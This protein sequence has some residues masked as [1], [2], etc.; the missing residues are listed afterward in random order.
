MKNYL[1]PF[2]L[3]LGLLFCNAVYG[4]ENAWIPAN[5]GIGEIAGKSNFDVINML[6]LDNGQI[7]SFIAN[8]SDGEEKDGVYL[9]ST[10]DKEWIKLAPRLN[11]Y[12][13]S[14]LVSSGTRIFAVSGGDSQ[15]VTELNLS[16]GQWEQKA[17][18]P[19]VGLN[20]SRGVD[21]LG[22]KL[23]IPCRI[24]SDKT[25]SEFPDKK[26]QKKEEFVLELDVPTGEISFLRNI[27]KPLIIDSKGGNPGKPIALKNGKVY[28]CSP[29]DYVAN[30]GFG[31]LYE[32]DGTDWKSAS[33]GLNGI[34][35]TGSGFGPIGPIFSDNK[36]EKLYIKTEQGFYQKA[37]G[38]WLKY[39][40]RTGSILAITED[41]LF[42]QG[43]SGNINRVDAALN[44]EVTN[45]GQK[46]I[47]RLASFVTP[48]N[49]KTF[50]AKVSVRQTAEGECSDNDDDRK[51]AGIFRFNAAF[52]SKGKVKNLHL[53]A[54][55]YLGGE[56]E[57][58]VAATA[59]SP[60][61]NVLVAG[62]F[63][64]NMG[65]TNNIL[66]GASAEGIGKILELDATGTEV[67]RATILGENISDMDV[68]SNGEVAVI[69]DFGV[70]VLTD[71][72]ALKWNTV[73]G[74]S[75]NAAIAI[76]DDGKVIVV[77]SSADQGA[78]LVKLFN[79]DG[80]L[81]HENS[82]M[83]NN[84]VTITDVEINSSQNQYFV[85]GYTQVSSVLQVAFLRAFSADND[86]SSNW[87]TWGF[88]PNEI[89]TNENGADT[90]LYRI[91]ATDTSL[92]M[93]GESA[94]G[95]PGGFT[96]F[97]YNG[98]DLSTK[99]ADKQ[100]DFFT[101][102]TNS[103]GSCHIT[104]L[105]RIDPLNG[106]V[107]TGKFFHGRLSGGKT[108]THRVRMGDLALD[109]A[110]NVLV[111]GEAAFQIQDRDVFN[112]NGQLVGPYSGDQY[113]LMT[114]PDFNTRLLWGVFSK[115]NGGGSHNRIATG[116]GKVAYLAQTEKG[117][118]ITSDNAIRKTPFNDFEEDG[119][120]ENPD[121]YF[122]LWDEEVWN[123]ANLDA[124]EL[125]FIPADSCFRVDGE[126]CRTEDPQ[127]LSLEDKL[128]PFNMIT[129]NGDN[130]NDTWRIEG[131]ELF[132][133]YMITVY[134]KNGQRVYESS[135]YRQ[136]WAGTYNGQPLP[137][138][139][140]YYAIIVEGE[141][142]PRTGFITILY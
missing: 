85:G 120:L 4:Q 82:T 29:F 108:N 111:V 118:M 87:K 119:K 92:Y 105:G 74:V 13:F 56:G 78:G 125:P 39:F 68:N 115:E 52:E 65:A 114:T 116:N 80:E 6:T 94:G 70:A 73:E 50:F 25:I 47:V 91:V 1:L 89:N 10:A 35:I 140:Y 106:T 34:N 16:T 38:G 44:T 132:N 45:K 107:L 62:N 129:P 66:L 12:G 59:I 32:W 19:K 137:G 42:I 112:V 33:L 46:C 37:D 5:A 81:V 60:A 75:D 79:A 100:N 103:C 93:A 54:G 27:N 83:D 135:R 141:Q 67:L 136:D 122:A 84:G 22:D 36:H 41:Y 40:Y 76:A 64:S 61:G 86:M 49:G 48:D 131:L 20:L 126:P 102:G 95:G 11:Q 71:V 43:S 26:F 53:E 30:D 139:V 21:A 18:L 121:V 15:N 99:V 51:N 14:A 72:L 127:G 138:G 134:S 133:T 57:N 31:G 96:V 58:T 142:K 124:V 63:S 8:H 101:D 123:T 90:R 3:T 97:A 69:G 17:N 28:T 110:G 77:L 113:V 104:F 2:I 24:E 109:G 7:Y 23:Y 88:G 117:T 55:T 128:K 130:R 98:K 9:Y